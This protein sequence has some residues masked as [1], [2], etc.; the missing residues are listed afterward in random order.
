[1]A[2]SR[3][4]RSA[5]VCPPDMILVS[6]I[7]EVTGCFEEIQE[8]WIGVWGFCLVGRYLPMKNRRYF[9]ASQQVATKVDWVVKTICLSFLDAL[10]RDAWLSEG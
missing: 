10:P 4:A 2:T 5:P 1:M 8:V 3:A 6:I 9:S 7:G